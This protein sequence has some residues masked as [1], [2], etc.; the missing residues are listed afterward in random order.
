MESEA[1]LGP[2]QS[3]RFVTVADGLTSS[4]VMSQKKIIL[5]GAGVLY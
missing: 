4:R 1:D 5:D 3:F 2:H